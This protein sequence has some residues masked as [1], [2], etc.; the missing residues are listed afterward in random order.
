MGQLAAH[1]DCPLEFHESVLSTYVRHSPLSVQKLVALLVSGESPRAL[2]ASGQGS[3][4]LVD[5]LVDTLG[6]QGAIARVV[7]PESTPAGPA[8]AESAFDDDEVTELHIAKLP[9]AQPE[10]RPAELPRE[11]T[12][13]QA[14]VAMHHEPSNRA[15]KLT[16]FAAHSKVSEESASQGSGGPF[17][18]RMRT[19]PGL[20]GWGFLLLLSA[21]AGFLMWRTVAPLVSTGE[22][23]GVLS[24]AADVAAVEVGGVA[25]VVPVPGA[26]ATPDSATLD[27]SSVSGHLRPGVDTNVAL[28]PGQGVLQL[29]GAPSVSVDV[30][31]ASQ[32]NLPLALPLSEGR[33]RV[34]Y[35]VG[36]ETTVRF[37]YVKA[38]ATR[39]LKLSLIHI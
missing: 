39:V 36:D 14:S 26:P 38:G 28:Q 17:E 31:G 2:W 8:G 35:H 21:T 18:L 24:E 27:L 16:S 12:R 10:E 9:E 34:R 30:D 3:R 15:P 25:P 23:T 13:A 29:T 7:V 1:P 22:A 19:G 6:R 20:L 32:G 11:A 33:H 37:Y 4:A 5:N